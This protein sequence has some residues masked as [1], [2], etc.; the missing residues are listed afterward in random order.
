MVLGSLNEVLVEL[1][2]VEDMQSLVPQKVVSRP[3]DGGDGAASNCAAAEGKARG[4]GV[5]HS[6]STPYMK[7]LIAPPSK[8]LTHD[9]SPLPEGCTFSTVRWEELALTMRRTDIPKTE[10]TLAVLGNVS[11]RYTRSNHSLQEAEAERGE[12][13]AW[14]FLGVDG[15][16]SSLHVEPAHRGRGL[17]K[18][19]S[20]TL[21]SGLVDDVGGMG[22]R[23]VGVEGK[24]EGSDGVDPSRGWACSDVAL[25]NRESAGVATGLGGQEG[26]IVRWVTIDLSKVKWALRV[27][28]HR[29]INGLGNI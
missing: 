14:A 12:L 29:D 4:R 17:A 7:W 1:L 23:S 16:L 5:L 25:E 15:S 26:W 6:I 10:A 11:V 20:R 2:A 19:V 22:F 9:T 27:R 3:V 8:G 24:G 18:A 21:F 13:I 28:Q